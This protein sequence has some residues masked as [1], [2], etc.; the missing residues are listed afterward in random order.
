MVLKAYKKYLL[1]LGIVWAVSLALFVAVF[2]LLIS[3]Q[4]E[5]SSKLAQELAEK[6]KLYESAVDADKEENKRKLIAEVAALKLQLGDFAVEFEESANLTFDVGR[7]AGEKRVNAFTVKTPDMSKAADLSDCKN[8][9]ENHI[10]ISFESDFRQFA[11]L[12]NALERHR[13]VF[14]VDRVKFSRGTIESGN[15][16]VD[17]GLTFLAKKRPEG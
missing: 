9:Q 2:I 16:R 13:P 3:P 15:H 17:M 4:L 6:K 1:T 12:L 11:T 10:D 5:V 14:F 8:L 7:I